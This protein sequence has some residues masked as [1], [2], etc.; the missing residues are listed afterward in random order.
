MKATAPLSG[1]V[2]RPT[3]R[4][5]DQMVKLVEAGED[6][7]DRLAEILQVSASTVRRDLAS[8]HEQG[9][10]AR[11]FGGAVIPVAAEQTW[12]DKGAESLP[13][14]RAIARYA[15]SLVRP[16]TL[17]ILDSGTTV[18]E[19][20]ALLS[21][22]EDLHLVTNGLN[23]ILAL[24]DG[25]AEVTVLGGRLRRP[26]ESIIGAE[27]MAALERLTAD[28]AFI[29]AEMLHPDR[30]VNC[31]EMPQSATKELMMSGSREAW[32]LADAS[33]LTRV[34]AH[35]Y[36]ARLEGVTG[37]ITDASAD[38]EMVERFRDADWT[39]HIADPMALIATGTD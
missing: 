12:R 4:R 28:I 8:L 14:K 10:L 24:A 35:P 34:N 33:K 27:T 21:E 15:A 36:W 16:G 19:V 20:A 29:G 17:V 3:R 26:S 18:A 13:Q 39:V 9:V 6:R 11:T 7:V 22:R 38:P 30:G 5:R 32:I 2:Y 37:L 31:P 25:S 23:S 1:A